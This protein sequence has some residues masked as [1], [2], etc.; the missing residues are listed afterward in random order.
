MGKAPI[1]LNTNINTGSVYGG[2]V[3]TASTSILE[4]E[5]LPYVDGYFKGLILKNKNYYLNPFYSNRIFADY[6]YR[7]LGIKD[8]QQVT[9]LYIKKK[10]DLSKIKLLWNYSL[11]GSFGLKGKYFNLRQKFLPFPPLYKIKF[12][13]PSKDRLV[14][15]NCRMSTNNGRNSI[16]YHRQKTTNI[17]KEKFK[18][19]VQAIPLNQYYKELKKTK[20]ALSPFGWGEI[21]YRDFEVISAGAALMKPSMEHIETWPDLYIK[22]KT[23]ISYSWDFIDLEEKLNIF[24]QKGNYEQIARNAQS[25]YGKYLSTKEGYKEFIQRVKNIFLHEQ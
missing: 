3:T 15:I 25:Y 4:P 23:Y 24:L 10:S 8:T 12:T 2:Q 14:D 9:P 1:Q 17:L 5:V 16:S 20:I 13:P 22:D 11:G 7:S 6:Y 19:N 21:N 18:L